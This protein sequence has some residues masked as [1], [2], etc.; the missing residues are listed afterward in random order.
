MKLRVGLQNK[1]GKMKKQK[2]RRTKRLSQKE[3][4]LAFLRSRRACK[5]AIRWIKE[6]KNLGEV[7]KKVSVDYLY[8]VIHYL[9]N[10]II[11]RGARKIIKGLSKKA[12][13]GMCQSCLEDIRDMDTI[14]LGLCDSVMDGVMRKIPASVYMK[15]LEKWI[16]DHDR[17]RSNGGNG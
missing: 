15:A 2:N 3:K 1:K 13:K 8:W 16:K 14:Y 17:K 7:V 5:Q 11:L 4:L 10:G 6:K 12:K 9:D